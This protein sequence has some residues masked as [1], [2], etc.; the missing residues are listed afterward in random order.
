[1]AI[2]NWEYLSFY[3]LD[4]TWFYREMLI[5]PLMVIVLWVLWLKVIRSALNDKREEAMSIEEAYQ[6]ATLIDALS[7]DEEDGGDTIETK[8]GL[9]APVT[10]E[11]L[12]LKIYQS[13]RVIQQKSFIDHSG[14]SDLCVG[15]IRGI[16]Y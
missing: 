5:I 12:N 7:T 11:D 15:V 14:N 13:I 16:Q 6:E 10:K 3:H 2:F 1:M 9:N 4:P 8:E